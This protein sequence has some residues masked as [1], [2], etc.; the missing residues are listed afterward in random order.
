MLCLLVLQAFHKITA[1]IP[2]FTQHS[3]AEIPTYSVKVIAERGDLMPVVRGHFGLILIL[4]IHA[5]VLIM[6]HCIISIN[7]PVS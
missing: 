1:T 5:A 2:Y 4:F 7:T 6:A 3:A